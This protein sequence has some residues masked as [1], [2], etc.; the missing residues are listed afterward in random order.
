MSASNLTSAEDFPSW[1]VLDH[2]IGLIY[3]SA[4]E[5]ARWDNTLTQ[6]AAGL[7]PLEWDV[8]FLVWER[9]QPA[10][11]RF[12]GATGLAPGIREIYASVYAGSNPW[13]R[14]IAALPVG[15]V[16][17]TDEIMAREEFRASP[18]YG[19]FLHRWGI[20]RALAVVLDRQGSERLALVMPGPAERSLEPLIRGLRA[21]A[22][23]IQRALRISH[24]IAAADIRAEAGDAAADLAPFGIL[25]LT[26]DLTVISANRAARRL[27]AS[28]LI[29]LSSG[30]LEF[31]D[32]EAQRRLIA[33]AKSA[34]ASSATFMVKD[35]VLKGEIA[36]D[37]L[38]VLAARLPQ[39]EHAV[40]GGWAQG[41]GLIVTVGARPRA[42][43]LEIDRLAAWFGLTPGEGRLAAALAAD[44]SLQDYARARNVSVN[45]ARFLLKGVY[46]KTGATS[47]AQLVSILRRLPPG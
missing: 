19:D 33:L 36:D 23:H 9:A 27:E 6:I 45:A 43:A 47:Q 11:A 31:R 1:A 39:R 8:A 34:Q 15:R 2:L 3:E 17:D 30:R 20:E 26:A 42:P 44:T 24:R 16:V 21:L 13:S 35:E 18:L 12:V 40:L 5:P 38:A 10:G 37:D 32:V 28:G 7:G 41:A 29:D 22:P 25:T 4:L 46:R 14:R